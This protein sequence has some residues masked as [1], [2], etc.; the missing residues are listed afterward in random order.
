MGFDPED[1]FKGNFTKP[2]KQE[3][4][5]V[6][7][8]ELDNHIM[9]AFGYTLPRLPRYSGYLGYPGK[10]EL[11][12]PVLCNHEPIDVGFA[13]PKMVCKICDKDL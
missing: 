9:D 7:P 5:K 13:S 3:D 11:P 1:H 10:E 8:V 12:L 6:C 4:V 2:K